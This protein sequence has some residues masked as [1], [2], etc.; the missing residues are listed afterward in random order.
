MN[1]IKTVVAGIIVVGMT[2]AVQA[3]ETGRGIPGFKTQS[4]WFCKPETKD[5]RDCGNGKSPNP[6]N[7]CGAVISPERDCEVFVV[8]QCFV[9]GS[10]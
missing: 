3:S 10:K 8:R 9:K 6:K 7:V 4:A 1:I 2:G 5:W